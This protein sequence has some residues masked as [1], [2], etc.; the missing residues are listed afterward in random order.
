MRDALSIMDQAIASTRRPSDPGFGSA[1]D[2]RGSRRMLE[3]VMQSVAAKSSSEKVLRL[4]DELINE[5]HRPHPFRAATGA[6]PTECHGGEDCGKDSSLLQVS[7][8][9]RERVAR[10]AAL[11]S[12]EDLARH[13]QIMLR[14]HGELG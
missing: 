2:W 5:G 9:E 7:S 6:V 13:L 3:S 11:F 4:V 12:E 10:V 1:T 8:D 14:T